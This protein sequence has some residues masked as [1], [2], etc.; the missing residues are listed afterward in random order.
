[1]ENYIFYQTK[2][3]YT[4]TGDALINRALIESL[5]KYGKVKCN[6][7][8]DIPKKFIDELG[9]KN[10]EKIICKNELDFVRKIKKATKNKNVYIV[11]GLGHNYGGGFKKNIR[12]IL[13]GI[14]FAIYR[15]CGVKIIRIGI[16]IGPITKVLALTEKFR[17]LSINE[18]L[19]RDTQSLELCHKIGIKKAKMCPDMSWLYLKEESRKI[20]K[21]NNVIINLRDWNDEKYKLTLISKCEESLRQLSKKFNG[22]INIKFTYQ[23]LEDKRFCKELYEYF[24]KKYTSIFVDEQITLNNAKEYYSD[25]SW[26]ISDRMHSLLLGYKF[27]ALPIALIDI[28]KN[29]KIF[30]TFKDCGLKDLIIDT[31]EKKDKKIQNIIDNNEIFMKKIFKVEKEKQGEIEDILE[32]IFK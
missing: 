18:Y 32:K 4:N 5:R 20:N 6:C 13:A 1:M 12:N 19:V 7:S 27:G 2:T 24:K 25:V 14:L 3:K 17:S 30:Q 26:N 31:Y 10:N 8:E 23:V 28:K 29:K 22:N 16:S 11:S 9:I 15:L 21:N